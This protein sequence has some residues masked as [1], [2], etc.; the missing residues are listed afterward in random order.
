MF[1]AAQ[2]VLGNMWLLPVK[3]TTLVG[4]YLHT[5]STSAGVSYAVGLHYLRGA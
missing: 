1:H 4:V 2:C 3:G 5:S